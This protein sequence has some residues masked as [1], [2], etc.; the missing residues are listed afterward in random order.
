MNSG[1]LNEHNVITEKTHGKA[2][3]IQGNLMQ[4]SFKGGIIGTKTTVHFS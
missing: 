1:G 4:Y 2:Q 3:W